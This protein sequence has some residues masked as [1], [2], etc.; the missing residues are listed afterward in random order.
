M[1][2][3]RSNFSSCFDFP[4]RR[5]A[6]P[7]VVVAFVALSGCSYVPAPLN[8]INWYKATVGAVFGDDEPKQAQAQPIP[9][10]ENAFPNLAD[11]PEAP[12]AEQKEQIAEGLRADTV[13]RTYDD[14][15]VEADGRAVIAVEETVTGIVPAAPV[16]PSDGT[17]AAAPRM[18]VEVTQTVEMVAV[19]PPNPV[20]AMLEAQLTGEAVALLETEIEIAEDEA[21]GPNS[22]DKF[23]SSKS[24]VSVLAG[25]I[26]FANGSANLSGRDRRE[27]KRIANDYKKSGGTVRVIGFASS[28]TGNVD[29]L[30]HQIINFNVS[31]RRADIVAA[32][33]MKHG[34]A[35]KD[36]FVG[37]KSDAEPVYYEVMPAGQAGNRRA[38]IYLDF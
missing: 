29:P 5:L 8:P 20:G 25:K 11:V 23:D 30:K 38:E 35:P 28:Y 9:G 26:L 13:N 36:I 2:V 3:F 18:E 22:L 10:E 19:A 32:S 15:L 33:L 31:M 7:V 14:E 4:A 21:M 6:Q 16:L 1:T 24:I 37:A 27:L 12:S 34:V 17:P